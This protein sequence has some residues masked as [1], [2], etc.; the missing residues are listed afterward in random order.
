MSGS[1][2]RIQKEV[3][4]IIK[5]HKVVKPLSH[6]SHDPASKDRSEATPDTLDADCATCRCRCN[7]NLTRIFLAIL[8]TFLTFSIAIDDLAQILRFFSKFYLLSPILFCSSIGDSLLDVIFH[9]VSSS[10]IGIHCASQMAQPSRE[11][12][13]GTHD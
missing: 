5:K 2:A 11:S 9:T 7:C 12:E 3:F 4:K 6:Q 13:Q 1:L 8:F 10:P